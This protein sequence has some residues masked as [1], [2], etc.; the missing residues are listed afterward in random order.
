MVATGR[1]R[2]EQQKQTALINIQKSKNATLKQLDIKY[3]SADRAKT[4]FGYVGITFLSVLFGS[5][6]AND[7]IKLCIYFFNNWIRLC[8]R[9]KE[10]KENRETI[11]G[12]DS[13]DVILEMDQK[14]SKE[15]EESLEN[16]YLRLAKSIAKKK[17][18]V[19]AFE[20]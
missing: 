4:S 13:D 7:F 8:K 12:D 5:I 14:Y 17:L 19:K 10:Y 20:I 18:S 3:A 2:I 1:A 11:D 16:F 9:K 6:F 15:L